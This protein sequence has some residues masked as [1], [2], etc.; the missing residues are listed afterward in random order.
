MYK[1]L[2]RLIHEINWGEAAKNRRRHKK[3][4]PLQA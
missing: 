3:D 4:P 2:H 1:R